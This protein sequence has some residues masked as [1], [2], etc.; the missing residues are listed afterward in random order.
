MNTQ[1]R[2]VRR[3]LPFALASGLLAALTPASQAAPAM[4]VVTVVARNSEKCLDVIADIKEDRAPIVQYTCNG[5]PNQQFELVPS[6]GGY[7][8]LKARSSGKC[9]DVPL[10]SKEDREIIQQYTCNRSESQ[11][12]QLVDLKDGFSKI[13]IRSSQKCLDVIQKSNDNLAPIIQFTCNGET[14]QQFHLQDV[15]P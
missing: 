7:Y 13:V 8:Q 12:F 6:G 1:T 14:N 9:L 5:R 2:F 15:T 11:Q 10:S 4:R 3:L